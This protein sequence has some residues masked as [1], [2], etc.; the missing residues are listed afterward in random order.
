MFRVKKSSIG[1]RKCE[2]ADYVN[3]SSLR[4][5]LIIR[6][7]VAAKKTVNRNFDLDF[8]VVVPNA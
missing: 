3:F 6:S 8:I 1:V 5:L 7:C 4:H 2:A